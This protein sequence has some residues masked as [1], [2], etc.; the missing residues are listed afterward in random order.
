MYTKQSL[1]DDLKNMGLKETDTVFVHSSYKKIAGSEGVEGGADTVIDTFIDY[2]GKKG[3][4]VFPAMSWKLG[5]LVNQNGE[6]RFPALGPK[7]G[8]SD[9]GN[10]FDINKTPCD[11]LGIIP[12][13]F[14]KRSGVVRSLCPSS[15]VAAFGPDAK[16][17]CAGHENAPTAFD[18]DYTWGNLYRR[19]AKTLFLGTTMACN[20]FMHIIE[21]HAYVP[22][23]VSPYIWKY[24]AVGYD[25][26]TRNIEMK[27]NVPGHNHYYRKVENEL[28]NNGIAEIHQFGAAETHLVDIV[29]ETDYMMKRL[30]ENPFLFTNND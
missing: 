22:G 17:F 18:W 21:E 2:F 16:E 7:E 27:R 12:E 10:H 4:V 6:L 19:K 11:G 8:F 1:T 24:T 14:R 29:K 23:I 5:Y 15:S 25:G 28:L 26:K 30:K 20:T 3:L 9:Y 13:L